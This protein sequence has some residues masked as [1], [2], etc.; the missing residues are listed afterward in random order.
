[1]LNIPAFREVYS[2]AFDSKDSNK[3]F[4]VMEVSPHEI[5]I[6]WI[7]NNKHTAKPEVFYLMADLTTASGT[8][9][10]IHMGDVVGG[11]WWLTN[12]QVVYQ[13]PAAFYPR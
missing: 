11:L 4:G 2:I 12:S 8:K 13:E 5:A 1:M 3:I 10:S 7:D 9:L 6:F